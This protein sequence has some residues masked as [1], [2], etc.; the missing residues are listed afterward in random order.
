MNYYD[1]L[2]VSKTSSLEEIKQSYK[3]L[4]IKNHP[5]KG[6]NKEKFQQI[7][8]AYEVLSDDNKRRQ[9]DNP[10]QGGFPQGFQFPF[11]GDFQQGFPNPFNFF[12]MSNNKN[13]DQIYK[14]KITLKDVY[15]GVTKTFN[16]KRKTLCNSC[17]KKCDMCNGVGMVN[18]GQQIQMGPIIQIIQK[19]C[20][21]CAGSGII[22]NTISCTPCNSSGYIHKEKNINLKIPKGVEEGKEYIFEEWGEQSNKPNE[23][24]GN[25]IVRI[26][27]ENDNIFTRSG[28]DLHYETNINIYE[29]IAGKKLEIPYFGETLYID[30]SNFCVINPNKEYIVLEKGLVNENGTK[31]NL[32]IKFKIEYPEKI[33]NEEESLLLSNLFKKLKLY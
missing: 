9:Y 27:I 18:S 28:L 23:K 6:G 32:Y 11:Q 13:N 29:S 30:T 31:G 4:V 16:I 7:Q 2:G 12:N 15:N 5:D 26:N 25:F 17:K 3:K 19:Q 33:L 14:C 8:E 1:I 24:S 10:N 20:E 21:K 22:K